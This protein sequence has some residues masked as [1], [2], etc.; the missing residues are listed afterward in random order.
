M[1]LNLTSWCDPNF[2]SR[3]LPKEEEIRSFFQSF[4]TT[5][6]SIE[7][8]F[9]HNVFKWNYSPNHEHPYRREEDIFPVLSRNYRNQIS[10][11][12]ITPFLSNLSP[13]NLSLGYHSEI[14]EPN[15][16]N[17]PTRMRKLPPIAFKL[18]K[19]FTEDLEFASEAKSI[20]RSVQINSIRDMVSLKSYI[21]G[22]IDNFI[23]HEILTFKKA[24]ESKNY[25]QTLSHQ[26]ILNKINKIKEAYPSEPVYILADYPLLKYLHTHCQHSPGQLLRNAWLIQG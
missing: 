20:E 23:D 25:I 3:K 21:N 22:Y 16:N 1:E 18:D 4:S 10:G 15:F 13:D 24:L 7:K 2:S 11:I 6:P 14:S 5:N 12:W 26:E 17:T 8:S 9:F 19:S